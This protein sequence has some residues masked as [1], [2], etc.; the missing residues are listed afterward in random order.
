MERQIAV[1]GPRSNSSGGTEYPFFRMQA[2]YPFFR[3]Q[4]GRDMQLIILAA[5]LATLA[6]SEAAPDI[7]TAAASSEVLTG[8]GS[9]RL[10]VIFFTTLAAPLATACDAGWFVASLEKQKLTEPIGWQRAGERY[11][12]LQLA[13]LWLWLAGSLAIIYLWKWPAIVQVTWGWRNWPLID[14]ALI[15]LPVLASLL[16][17]WATFFYVEKTAERLKQVAPRRNSLSSY[18]VWN[19]RHYLAMA[20]V[21]AFLVLAGQ[22]LAARYVISS[23]AWLLA[24]PAVVL[25]PC[26]LPL[27]LRWLWPT[28]EL[29]AGEL[30]DRIVNISR[31]L[32]TP[33]TR[34]LVWQTQGRMTNAAVAGLSRWCRYLFLTDALLLELTPDEIAAVV[35]HELGHLQRLH[36]LQRLLVL[37]LPVLAGFALQPLP[38]FNGDWLSTTSP[39]AL[40]VS[41]AY[42]LYALLIVAPF[43]R[44]LEYD[45]DLS[46]FTNAASEVN[47]DQARDLIH[48]L[49]VLQGPQRE[50]RLA[51]LL[52]PP[53]ASRI[54]W[55]R[56]VLLNPREGMAYR[57]RL[58]QLARMIVAIISGLVGL[59]ALGLFQ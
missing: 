56:R 42:V 37:A 18:L 44:W 14:D 50:S 30:R 19:S 17:I 29:P 12:R 34:L 4:A 1:S 33:L 46:A 57:C 47:P 26:A 7:V 49:V 36:L 2:E 59:I 5:L 25:A 16:L 39:Y 58:D 21:P 9:W 11:E 28:I 51:H 32:Q 52:H 24:I 54:S 43:S 41:A 3:M 31:E 40:A 15:L 38:G 53:T 55:I 22:E 6:H 20:L 48:A 35:R 10:L 45:A 8:F 23:S 27:L 13:A